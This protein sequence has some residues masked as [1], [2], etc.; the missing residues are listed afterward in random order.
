MNEATTANKNTLASATTSFESKGD[1]I[2]PAHALAVFGFGGRLCVMMPQVAKSLSGAAL[3]SS[4]DGPK[5]MRR[6]PIVIHQ[7]RNLIPRDHKYSVPANLRL[8]MIKSPDQ[9]VKAFL[10]KKCA[11]TESLVWKVVHLA[12]Q[13][14][15]R[16]KDDFGAVVDLLLSTKGECSNGELKDRCIVPQQPPVSSFTDLKVIQ[17]KL[18]SVVS[19]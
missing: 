12:A 1:R 10:D 17:S 4:N 14:G 13:N 11:E 2:R 19:S 18:V 8:P 7:L 6:G 3:P 9:D 5:T 16:L 15:G